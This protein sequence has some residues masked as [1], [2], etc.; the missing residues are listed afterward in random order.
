MAVKAIASIAV[1]DIECTLSSYA[2][3]STGQCQLL[4]VHGGKVFAHIPMRTSVSAIASFSVGGGAVDE[5]VIFA[6][7][8]AG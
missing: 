1:K 2:L 4:V 8:E 3:L 5:D 6:A 7:G